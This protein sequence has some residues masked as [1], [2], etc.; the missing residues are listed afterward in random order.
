MSRINQDELTD[1][2][3]VNPEG[4]VQPHPGVEFRYDIPDQCIK[5]I[6]QEMSAPR[7]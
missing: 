3:M 1:I 2:K 5:L 6:N 7:K 4:Y